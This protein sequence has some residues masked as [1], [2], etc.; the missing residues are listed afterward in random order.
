M[1][2]R[3]NFDFQVSGS[4]ASLSELIETVATIADELHAI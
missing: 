1:N 3:N 4:V 2:S